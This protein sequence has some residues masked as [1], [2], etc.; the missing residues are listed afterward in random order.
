MSIIAI[1]FFVLAIIFVHSSSMKKK[2]TEELDKNTNAREIFKLADVSKGL[3]AIISAQ[4]RISFK[5][6]PRS[7]SERN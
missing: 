1:L 2:S 4:K 7:I 6:T 3:I 5:R